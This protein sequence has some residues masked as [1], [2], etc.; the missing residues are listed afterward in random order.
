MVL[1][2][3]QALFASTKETYN[4]PTANR[5]KSRHQLE[6]HIQGRQS[7]VA[8]ISDFQGAGKS[9][10]MEMAIST[11]RFKTETT[12]MVRVKDVTPERLEQDLRIFDMLFVDDADIRT[13]WKKIIKGLELVRDF[14]LT[15]RCPIVVSGDFTIRDEGLRELFDPIP[16]REITMEPVDRQFFLEALNSRLRYLFGKTKEEVPDDANYMFDDELLECLVPNS[17][18]SVATFREILTLSEGLT[19][20]IEPTNDAFVLSKDQAILYCSSHP[21]E[22]PTDQ[23]RPFLKS[24]LLPFITD[25]H[26]RGRGMEPFSAAEVLESV[27]IDG[28]E[29]SDSLS[30]LVL[31]PLCRGGVL[32]ALGFPANRD[33]VFDRYPGPYLPRPKLLLHAYAESDS[34]AMASA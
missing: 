24:W 7:E 34:L 6:E 26:P 2:K 18:V 8:Y 28:V 16:R 33:G 10:L 29:D 22:G 30:K 32:H 3:C 5:D 15:H 19:Y 14:G 23:Q 31:E 20:Q 9:T 11:F 12:A 1:E 17:A 21:L 13:S 4:F 25:L 27:A